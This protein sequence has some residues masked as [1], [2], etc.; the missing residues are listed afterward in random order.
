MIYYHI[1]PSTYELR[2]RI[3]L[4]ENVPVHIWDENNDQVRSFLAQ[5]YLVHAQE[6]YIFS[7]ISQFL[8]RMYANIVI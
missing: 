2:S 7:C 5:G 6:N 3:I 8:Q 1:Y 4:T